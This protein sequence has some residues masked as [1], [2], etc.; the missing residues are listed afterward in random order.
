[1]NRSQFAKLLATGPIAII[2][3]IAPVYGASSASLSSLP[4]LQAR[5]LEYVGAFRVPDGD[6]PDAQGFSFGGGPMAYN[7]LHNSLFIG[8]LDNL[9]AEV[10]IPT[11]VV[12][13]DVSVL[14]FATLLQ[15]FADPTEGTIG[16]MSGGDLVNLGGLLV[17]NGKLYG[18][19]YLYYD[20]DGSQR[21]SHYTRDLSLNA[22]SFSGFHSLWQANLTGFV[23]GYLATVPDDWQGALGGAAIT[24]QCCI[25]IVS[26]TSWG[27][28]AVSWN[29]SDVVGDIELIP[30]T[31]LVLYTADHPTLGQWD[32]S[33]PVY[34]G[35]TQMGGVAL[36]SG[37]RTALYFG[38]NGQGEFCYGPGTDDPNMAGQ[39]DA[40]G[41]SYC[42]DPVSMDKGPHAY[43]Y[44][45]QIW[46]YDLNDLAAVKAGTMQMW[47]VRPYGVWQFALPLNYGVTLGGVA[48]DANRQII[49]VSQ[50][51]AD[52]DGYAYRPLIHT[53]K[54]R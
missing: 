14:S 37:T 31:P 34:G 7:P 2:I 8:T 24:G 17:S 36:V 16:N 15:P 27:P 42:Y 43:P 18:T 33:N 40:E 45:F 53:F 52:Q 19:A 10:S 22:P 4:L 13:A 3:A 46:A 25:P 39:P 51:L 5:N 20:A 9:L 54:I 12:S 29:P 28:D 35:T 44:N 11:P 50:L 32:E 30:A 47:D 48:Y 38:S 41:G 1:M 23:S 49:Y 26:R 21:A 6:S